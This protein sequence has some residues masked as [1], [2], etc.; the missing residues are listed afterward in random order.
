MHMKAMG[1]KRRGR[2]LMRWAWLA[3]VPLCG[4]TS[5]AVASDLAPTLPSVWAAAGALSLTLIT[6]VRESQK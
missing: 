2:R 1:R 3:A 4:V 5:D 6:A